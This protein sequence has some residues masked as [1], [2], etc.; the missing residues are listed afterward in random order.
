MKA[1]GSDGAP[2]GP[3]PDGRGLWARFRLRRRAARAATEPARGGRG[4]RLTV[5]LRLALA[6]AATAVLAGLL[7]L[8]VTYALL[9]VRIRTVAGRATASPGAGLS[10]AIRLDGASH[11]LPIHAADL[12]DACRQILPPYASPT[13][14]GSPGGAA[15]RAGAVTQT[16]V[17]ACL[18]A[19]PA[20]PGSSA[21]PYE[22][23]A[24]A[25]RSVDL[26]Q[27]LALGGIALGALAMLSLGAGW[28]MAGRILKPLQ[29]ITRRAQELSAQVPLGRIALEGPPDELR[30]LAATIDG[31]LGRLDS[32]LAAER[33][34]VANASHELRT[35][36]AIQSTV[37]DVALG[38]PAA[39]AATLREAAQQV[40][41][42]GA[43]S[44]RVIDG[45][46]ALARSQDGPGRGEP[47]D[48]ARAARDAVDGCA[49]EAAR[50]GVRIDADL[51]PAPVRGDPALL[52]RMAAN[53]VENAVRYN[54]PPGEGWA[55]V[56]TGTEGGRA[57]LRVT[58]SGPVLAPGDVAGLFEPFR[59]GGADRTDGHRGA[60]LGLSIVRAVVQ[61]HGGTVTAVAR[62]DGGLEAH[63][64]LPL[65]EP[66]AG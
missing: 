52:E 1:T 44:Q 17:N 55:A 25:Q 4:P 10:L 42:V 20:T 32:A 62:P 6:T 65:H 46:L 26:G 49:I 33:R 37:L 13:Q 34:F 29:V 59:R 19:L 24:L 28:W 45:L 58:N 43:R 66:G 7:A 9:S 18:A 53:L 41:E 51:R 23:I 38:D 63:V 61:A 64:T 31:L 27:F 8:G 11:A 50:R 36:L 14:P 60:G 47:L 21:F 54:L 48:L 56:R 2:P 30:D 35:P 5:R 15:S 22:A 40:R 39:D 16:A 12:P 57:V 3:G